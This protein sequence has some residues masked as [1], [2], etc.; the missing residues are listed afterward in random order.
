M[1]NRYIYIMLYANFFHIMICY[2]NHA[3]IHHSS[4]RD[5]I[6]IYRYLYNLYYYI[7]CNTAN[8]DI[9]ILYK[10]WNMDNGQSSASS[11]FDLSHTHL[12]LNKYVINNIYSIYAYICAGYKYIYIYIS[13]CMYS[14]E[15]ITP[16]MQ[17]GSWL[18]GW[19]K[20][21]GFRCYSHSAILNNN[22]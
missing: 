9:L 17:V 1:I 21:L 16:P 12:T 10:W 20:F 2:Q 6:Y 13:P 4:C 11:R 22:I 18:C 14:T 3:H 15:C 8:Y 7:I 5:H 19:C